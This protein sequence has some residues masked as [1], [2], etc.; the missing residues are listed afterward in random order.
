M[1]LPEAG[2]PWPPPAMRAEYAEIATHDAWYSGDPKRLRDLYASEQSRPSERRRWW[3]WSARNGP[4]PGQ[5]DTRVHIPLAGDIATTSA[6]LLFAEPPALSVDTTATQDRLA[7][8]TRGIGRTLAEAAE[9]SSAL[10]GVFLRATWDLEIG[11]RPILT[12][13][14]AD[15]AVPE[16]RLGH[17]IAVTFWR[18]LAWNGAVVLRHLERHEPGR[19]W[20]G[21]YQ[22]TR[23]QLGRPVPLTEHPD[24]AGLADSLGEDGQSIATGITDL[25]AAYIPNVKPNRR[26]RGSPFGRSDFQGIHHLFDA[27]D[28]T[29][30]SWQR[31]IRIGAGRLIVPNQYLTSRGMGKGAEFD[32]REIWAGINAPPDGDQGLT[33][34]QFAIRVDEHERSAAAAMSQAVRLAGYSVQSFGLT[35]DVAVTA[36][37]VTA[38]ERRSL[39]TRGK[40]TE[41]ETDPVEYMACVMLQLD[42]VLGFTPGLVVER[43][44]LHWPDGVSEDPKSVAETLSLL[45]QAGAISTWVKVRRLNPDWDDDAV[46][47]EVARI[48]Q[49]HGTAVPDPMQAGDLV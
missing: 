32:D 49:E 3:Q 40:K 37:E 2:V 27:L 26:R 33:I 36:T 13:I 34:N 30:T 23:D 31:D 17:L 14:H 42:R 19:I 43:P 9:V 10:G 21:V 11:A 25:T 12:V 46:D 18:E 47:A 35:G 20:H 16:M 41:Y 22:G 39:T 45:E 48:Q 44:V 1:P 24:T 4:E 6:D 29:W 5:R 7:E 15:C 28:H 8:I 38:R